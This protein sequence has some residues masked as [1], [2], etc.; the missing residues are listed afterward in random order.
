VHYSS[1]YYPVGYVDETYAYFGARQSMKGSTGASGTITDATA[2]VDANVGT[3]SVTVAL[4]GTASAR[5]FDFAFKN[6]KGSPGNSIT[7]TNLSQNNE[8]G[9][10]SAITFSD[11]KTLNVKNGEDGDDGKSVELQKTSSHIQWRQT[12]GGWA[13]LV[14]LSDLKGQDGGAGGDGNDGREI[15]LRKSS[16][17]VQWHYVGE[18][19]WKNLIALSDLKGTDGK[20]V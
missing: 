6:L 1:Y 8:A 20:Q 3:P 2:S 4:G 14:A 16:D 5:T 17:Y 18:T 15:E 11:G 13:D 10:T 7:I 9:G 19:G 12:N